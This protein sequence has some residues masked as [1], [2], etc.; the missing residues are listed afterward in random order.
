MKKG[1]IRGILTCDPSW[2][3]LAFTIH[4]PSLNYN[5][6]SVMDM[7][8]LLKNKKTLTQPSVYIPLVVTVIDLFLERRPAVYLCDKLIIETQFMENMKTLSTVITSVLLTRLPH[9]KTEKLS[10][11]TCKRQHSVSYGNGHE[12]NK[13]KMLQYVTEN[14]DKLIAGDT[15]KDHNTADSIILLNTWLNLKTRHLY[16]QPEEYA[17][18]MSEEQYFDVPFE[19]KNA[20]WIC[21]ACEQP[22]AKMWLCKNAPK[23]PSKLGQF[24]M[25]C[26]TPTCKA[27]AF[28]GKKPPDVVNGRFGSRTSP[29]GLWIK[30]SSA[31]HQEAQVPG[32]F[33]TV[34]VEPLT[35]SKRKTSSSSQE[36]EVPSKKQK[37]ED[38]DPIRNLVHA[39]EG[40]QNELQEKVLEIQSKTDETLSKIL[41]AMTGGSPIEVEPK[42]GRA[43]KRKESYLNRI[44]EK[45]KTKISADDLE[46]DKNVIV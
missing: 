1:F 2:R 30:A 44:E 40:K 27:C 4:L 18:D 5:D 23:D 13:K 6:S 12:D 35:G 45:K 32:C 24:F 26:S 38:F 7:S 41:L 9:M 43:Q 10:A 25:S 42:K 31:V 19:F 15:V 14:K 34:P 3:G 39:L 8:I 11:L 29:T 46:E 20:R 33:N 36:E 28:L 21:S 37:T 22:N 17:A 16:K